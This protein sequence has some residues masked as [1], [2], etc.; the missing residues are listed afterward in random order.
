MKVPASCKVATGLV[1]SVITSVSPV[2]STAEVACMRMSS[3]VSV[4]AN[5]WMVAAN[6]EGSLR[7][8]IALPPLKVMRSADAAVE[9]TS[10]VAPLSTD[11]AP[12]SVIAWVKSSVPLA[13]SME[14]VSMTL[15]PMM[16]GAVPP[17]LISVP[18][19]LM[20]D[21]V[22]SPSAMPLLFSMSQVAPAAIVRVAAAD[23]P[24]PIVTLPL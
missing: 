11:I 7:A 8:R 9:S 5:P 6:A 21:F 3:I 12:V 19:F 20:L 15:T 10:S 18:L 2:P 17:A 14:P 13:A 24:P 4:G 16:L 1:P 23:V 22:E